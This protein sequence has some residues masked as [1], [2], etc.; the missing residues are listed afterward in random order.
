[1]DALL[2][3]SSR[4]R[5]RGA[6]VPWSG[7]AATRIGVLLWGYGWAVLVAVAGRAGLVRLLTC[8][9]RCRPHLPRR[10]P[11]LPRRPPH[12]RH[13]RVRRGIFCSNPADCRTRCSHDLSSGSVDWDKVVAD[14]SKRQASGRPPRRWSR[15]VDS[16]GVQDKYPSIQLASGMGASVF[17]ASSRSNARDCTPGIC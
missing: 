3:D 2:V 11:H 9:R 16:A 15:T 4:G 5:P 13:C 12:L 7:G 6:P 17:A 1:M 14:A 10:R 8:L